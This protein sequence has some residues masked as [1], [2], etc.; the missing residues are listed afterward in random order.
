MSDDD[1]FGKKDRLRLIAV[2]AWFLV[3]VKW[4]QM[5]FAVTLMIGGGVM[6]AFNAMVLW[7]TV[8]RKRGAPSVAPIFGGVIAA[9]G[10][11]ILPAAGSWKWAWIPLVID[12]GGLPMFLYHGIIERLK[13]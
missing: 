9:I 3:F 6:I 12:W 2:I 4:P 13:K 11:G 7:L 5:V 10:V 8:V 1:R